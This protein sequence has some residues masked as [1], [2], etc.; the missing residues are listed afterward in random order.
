MNNKQK[1]TLA[2]LF[3][4]P[5]PR[6]MAW[7]DLESMLK[8]VGA[9]VTEGDGSRVKFDLN[10]VT[11]AFHRPH[12]PKTV[13]SYQMQIAREFLESIGVKP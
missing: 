5:P 6:D 8:A 2:A 7:D 10:G 11:A 4:S 13:R 9:I 12:K 1:K 3:A